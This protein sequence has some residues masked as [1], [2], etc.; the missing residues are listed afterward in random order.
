[1]TVWV[2]MMVVGAAALGAL[3]TLLYAAA[4]APLGYQDETGFHLGVPPYEKVGHCRARPPL[5]SDAAGA[6]GL[7]LG[8]YF[9][10][11]Q[12]HAGGTN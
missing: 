1:M 6:F 4:T 12:T 8:D 11:R 2:F 3:I 9:A 10:R 5:E 7:T